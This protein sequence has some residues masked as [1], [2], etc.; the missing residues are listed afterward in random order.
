M[1]LR[2]IL[3]AVSAAALALSVMAFPVNAAEEL[4][5]TIN[6]RN[7]T[8]WT[9]IPQ[10]VTVNGNGTYTATWDVS[11]NPSTQWCNFNTPATEPA[12][13]SYIGSTITLD[14]FKVNDMDWPVAS[15]DGKNK[16]D[17]YAVA[18]GAT[19]GTINFN[20][21]N[22]WYEVG[23]MV[24]MSGAKATANSGYTFLDADGNP[25]EVTKLEVTFTLDGVD[26]VFV[27]GDGATA[28]ASTGNAPV[29]LIGGIA[30]VALAGAL[31]SRKRK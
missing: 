9:D 4:T 3:A 22:I 11:D 7:T 18:E 26:G 30:A 12:P 25:I 6:A 21:W 17:F 31:I 2:K 14:S 8:T 13:E 1:K 15:A 16:T 28:S 10:S 27:A 23:N 29:A 5:F 24:D 19:E 20:F